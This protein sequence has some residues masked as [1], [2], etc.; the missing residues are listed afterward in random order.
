MVGD[1]TMD[2]SSQTAL[3]NLTPSTV[4]HPTA[5]P[6]FFCDVVLK[7]V[8]FLIQALDQVFLATGSCTFSFVTFNYHSVDFLSTYFKKS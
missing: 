7:L 8:S 3:H 4:L 2:D 6:P 1:P 5:P